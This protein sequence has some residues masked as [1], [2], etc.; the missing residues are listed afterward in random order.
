MAKR[1]RSAS[2]H[3]PV[4]YRPGSL[5]SLNHTQRKL[6]EYSEIA[7]WGWILLITTWSL[8]FFAV[9]TM[10]DLD[11]YLFGSQTDRIDMH[12]APDDDDDFPIRMYYPTS[13]FLSLVMA[14]VWCIVSWMGLK[15]FK[16]AKVDPTSR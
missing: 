13:F 4:A 15:F 16:H 10:F 1:P 14:W 7:S 2:H 5:V 12:K 9:F 6:T 3:V 8:I 11:I